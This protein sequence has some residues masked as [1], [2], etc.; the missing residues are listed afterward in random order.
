MK[1]RAP[2]LLVAACLGWAP[3]AQAAGGAADA[4]RALYGE[5][6]TAESSDGSGPDQ[7]KKSY[8]TPRV[9][10]MIRR[11]IAACKGKDVCLPD[12]DFL[13]DGQDFKVRDLVIVTRSETDA[14]AVVEA[15]FKNFDAKVRRVF[16]MRQVDGR[17]LIDDIDFGRGRRLKDELKPN[18]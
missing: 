4:V 6:A 14:S 12:A 7:L 8:Y 18:P 1:M 17:W 10:G 9:R 2:V 5:Y 11:L 15:T 3:L 16:T 13:V